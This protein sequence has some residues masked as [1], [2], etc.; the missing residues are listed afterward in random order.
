MVSITLL[1]IKYHFYAVVLW[2]WKFLTLALRLV[3]LMF[4][5][6]LELNK[7]MMTYIMLPWLQVLKHQPMN[8]VTD[9]RGE[10][11]ARTL[12]SDICNCEFVAKACA[13]CFFH[14][15]FARFFWLDIKQVTV[16]IRATLSFTAV[17]YM[18]RGTFEQSYMSSGPKE[19]PEDLIWEIRIGMAK[20]HLWKNPVKCQGCNSDRQER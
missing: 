6:F 17:S 19:I 18:S 11:R 9:M 2:Y 10:K 3:F 15:K 12:L 1:I 13:L 8:D 5:R 20:V 14:L 4:L 7:K 16:K